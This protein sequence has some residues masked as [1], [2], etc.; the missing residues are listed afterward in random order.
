MK[1]DEAIA[2]MQNRFFFAQDIGLEEAGVVLEGLG[3][4]LI[5]IEVLKARLEQAKRGLCWQWHG[6]TDT[7]VVDWE[8]Y[9]TS[10]DSK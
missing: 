2:R 4:A 10:G 3:G 8:A 1:L 9:F 7:S 5:E 6:D